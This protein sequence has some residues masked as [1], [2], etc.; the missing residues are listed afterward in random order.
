MT[1]FPLD[2]TR[3]L[4]FLHTLAVKHDIIFVPNN[5]SQE[6]IAGVCHW[7]LVMG[8][9]ADRVEQASLEVDR[10]DAAAEACTLNVTL[11]F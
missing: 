3:L 8:T 9:L 10:V 6:F 5:N 4:E 7:L 11:C 1:S 2:Q